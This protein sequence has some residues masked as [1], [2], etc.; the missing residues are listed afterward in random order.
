MPTFSSLAWHCPDTTKLPDISSSPFFFTISSDS[1]VSSD[2][3]TC[4]SPAQTSASAHIWLPAL[5]ITISS[6]TSSSASITDFCPSRT[7]VAWGA[8]SIVRSSST[9]FARTSCTI[10]INVF[11]IMTGRN[12]RSRKDPAIHKRIARITNIRL[13]YVNTLLWM[14]SF[15]VLAGGS[16]AVFVQ[17]CRRCSCTCWFV[18]P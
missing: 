13:K 10:P 2:S 15:V 9:F 8:F 17:P 12:V 18:S 7:T 11:S 3:F 1:P 16:T 14:I 4:T 6:S 5:K